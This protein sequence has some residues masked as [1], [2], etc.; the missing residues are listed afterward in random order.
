MN[1]TLRRGASKVVFWVAISGAVASAACRGSDKG[2]FPEVPRGIGAA[3]KWKEG[4]TPRLAG[5]YAPCGV[6][7]TGQVRGGAPSPDGAEIAIASYAGLVLFASPLT[8]KIVGPPFHASGPLTSV[9]YSRDGKLVVAA[10]PGGVTI[11]DRAD[12][13]V[14]FD[15]QP[16]AHASLSAS[17]SPDGTLLAV[18]GWD[19]GPENPMGM[20]LMLRLIRVAD[21]TKVAEIASNFDY[22]EVPQFTPDGKAV[23]VSSGFV[24]V[25]TLQ[26]L[27][28]SVGSSGR[29]AL[30]RD[31]KL[32]AQDSHVWNVAT[33]QKVFDSPSPGQLISPAFSPDGATYAELRDGAGAPRLHLYRTS[34]WSLIREAETRHAPDGVELVAG[35]IF[36]SGDGKRILVTLAPSVGSPNQAPVYSVV[37]VPGLT[38]ERAIADTKVF[39][40]GPVIFSPDGS[41]AAARLASTAGIWRGADLSP[42]SQL[43][44]G[45]EHFAFLGNGTITPFDGKMFDPATGKPL[46]RVSTFSD[47]ISPDGRLAVTWYDHTV[48]RL[49]DL[50]T[51]STLEYRGVLPIE[52]AL[53]T[54]DNRFVA[55]AGTEGTGLDPIAKLFV[56]DASTGKVVGSLPAG[57]LQ[58]V[59]TTASGAVRVAAL[60]ETNTL[61][62]W[63]VPDG[64]MLFELPGVISFSVDYSFL[65][66]FSPDGSLIAVGKKTS[67]LI[68]NAE[69]GA[70]RES[71]SAHHDVLNQGY[72]VTSLAFSPTGQLATVGTDETLRLWCSP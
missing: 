62:V 61:R 63:S 69:T 52:A 67:I 24:S 44:E 56:F 48:E 65:A 45:G 4:V 43:N 39:W 68:M 49:A 64:K 28:F 12:R 11:F 7:G 22:G 40:A 41:F 6:V 21:G 17:L 70:F 9:A 15:R 54:R 20:V 36:F 33:G 2:L 55:M 8:G 31:G 47:S 32:V 60:H 18:Q 13:R 10:G 51:Q 29:L 14:I 26:P 1:G 57:R 71:L 37:S 58:A 42:V 27:P 35:P 59:T 23:A 50:S 30:S 5:P 66:D 19:L 53:F 25:P 46:A 38:F 72:G 16:F 34:D 3:W